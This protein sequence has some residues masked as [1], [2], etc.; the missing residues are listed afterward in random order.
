MSSPH[1]SLNQE[2]AQEQE[3]HE[4]ESSVEKFQSRWSSKKTRFIVDRPPSQPLSRRESNIGI[5]QSR[6][7]SKKTRFIVDRTPSQPL[8]RRESAI[9]I[10]QESGSRW[11]SGSQAAFDT[12]SPKVLA[13]H[14]K[15]VPPS[16]VSART[17]SA[18]VKNHDMKLETTIRTGGTGTGTRLQCAART[19]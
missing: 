7:S 14:R 18:A 16:S 5:I 9:G 13:R 15:I 11:S 2:N 17:H 8:S 10:I 12:A 4:R 19:A 1:H 6:W 3:R